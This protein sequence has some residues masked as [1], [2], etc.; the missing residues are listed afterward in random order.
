MSDLSDII[1]GVRSV[2]TVPTGTPGNEMHNQAVY[3]TLFDAFTEAA[4]NVVGDERLAK[5]II[6]FS[7]YLRTKNPDHINWFGGNLLGVERI[8]FLTVDNDR[9]FDEVIEVDEA[10]L[11]DCVR[12]V[13]SI[14]E[15]W[16]VSSDVF[17]IS[18][19]WVLH[20][21][22]T[23]GTQ[24]KLIKQAQIEV[25][26]ILQFKYYTSIWYNFFDRCPVDKA[27]AEATYQALSLKFRLRQLG[28][29]GA[30]LEYQAAQLVDPSGTRARTLRTFAEDKDVLV[31]VTDIN[32]RCRAVV[33]DM[34]GPLEAVRS[35]N[36]RINTTGSTMI[37]VDGDKIIKD[38]NNFYTT[39]SYY[40]KDA[41]CNPTNFVRSDLVQLV[42][43]IMPTANETAL[44]E[45]LNAM[46]NAPEGKARRDVNWIIDTTLEHA[47]EY[48]SSNRIRVTDAGQILLKLRAIYTAPKT[49]GQLLV[50]LRKELEKFAKKNCFLN[51]SS[52]I[53]SIRTA[54]LLYLVLR[55]LA[56]N[57]YR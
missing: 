6:N 22:V 1:A 49:S 18:T 4:D 46:A 42:M 9:W 39:A 12:S 30:L 34:Y 40:L 50:E 55:C 11:G 35:G 3:K 37:S 27:A 56:V 53:A 38:T 47:F 57:I 10:Y 36:T 8:K 26:V 29:W 44:L 23:A 21:L 5:R 31:I 15:D 41:A 13:P 54:I 25:G 28:S 45:C 48:I 32:T 16:V 33:K 19:I 17:N 52:A 7:H 14:N 20:R 43:D 2:L 51:S 24:S